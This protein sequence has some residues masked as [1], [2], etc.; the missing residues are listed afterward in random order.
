MQIYGFKNG[1]TIQVV[2]GVFLHLVL[3]GTA[4]GLAETKLFMTFL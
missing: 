4:A 3:M 2:V 1:F